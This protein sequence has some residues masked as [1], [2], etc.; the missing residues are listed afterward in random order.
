MQMQKHG[1]PWYQIQKLN[2]THFLLTFDSSKHGYTVHNSCHLTVGL[3]DYKESSC[4]NRG[5]KK[6]NI[7]IVYMVEIDRKSVV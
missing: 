7:D 1:P 2:L 6:V 4:T 5:K 3:D